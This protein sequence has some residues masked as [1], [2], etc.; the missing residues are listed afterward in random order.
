MSNIEQTPYAPRDS[1][2][3]IM[4]G[5]SRPIFTHGLAR[6]DKGRLLIQSTCTHCLTSGIV[7]IR[8]ASLQHWEFRHKCHNH[9]IR[10]RLFRHDPSLN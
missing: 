5:E 8:D 2:F 7:S 3:S 6:D 1:L 9:L 10:P 4:P